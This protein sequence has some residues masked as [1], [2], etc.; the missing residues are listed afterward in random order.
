MVLPLLW[1]A[2]VHPAHA[3]DELMLSWDRQT[4][5]TDLAGPVFD[6]ASRWVPGDARTRGFW[7]RSAATEPARLSVRVEVDDRDDLLA[8]GD[9]S[10]QL[11]VGQEPWSGLTPVP[12]GYRVDSRLA[13]DAVTRVQVRVSFDPAAPNRSQRDRLALD[14]RIRLTDAGSTPDDDGPDDGS[15]DDPDDRGLPDTG[16]P[17]LGWLILLAGAAL[18]VGL[19]LMRRKDEKETGHGTTH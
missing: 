3:A 9:L 15:P 16:A 14:F 13:A 12:G 6:P 7:V 19:A 8:D 18:G 2:S 11:R 4:W 17:L 5:T 10:L 1:G